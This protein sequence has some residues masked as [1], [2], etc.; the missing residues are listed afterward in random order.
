MWVP[1][2]T[3]LGGREIAQFF[4]RYYAN[5]IGRNVRYA[6][7]D[8]SGQD[9]TESRTSTNRTESVE[10]SRRQLSP[11]FDTNLPFHDFTKNVNH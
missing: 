9:T 5:R 4:G 10:L 8:S 11:V 3:R 6:S 7:C 2:T 1:K